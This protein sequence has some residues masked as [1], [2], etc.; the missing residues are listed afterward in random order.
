MTE[1]AWR[2][3]GVAVALAAALLGLRYGVRAADHQEA[4]PPAAV[5]LVQ[6]ERLQQALQAA[7]MSVPAQLDGLPAGPWPRVSLPQVHPADAA[8]PAPGV[9]SWY[10][11]T[12]PD[13]ALSAGSTAVLYVPR[14]HACLVLSVYVDG[15]LAT[16]TLGRSSHLH[17]NDPLWL[18]RLP[19][20]PGAS[21]HEL[22]LRLDAATRSGSALSTLWVGPGT[23]LYPGYELRRLLQRGVPAATSAAFLLLGLFSGVVWLRRRTESGYLLFFAMSLLYWLRC[24]H[25]YV[26]FGE[27]PP[28]LIVVTNWITVNALGWM[29]AVAYLFSLRLHGRRQ[30]RIEWPLFGLLLA[31]AVLTALGALGELGQGGLIPFA[32]NGVYPAFLTAAVGL[33]V[34]S[35]HAAWRA[36][37]ADAGWVAASLWLNIALGA[38]DLLLQRWLIDVEGVYLLP[39]GGVAMCSVFGAVIWRRYVEALRGVEQANEHLEQRLAQREQELQASFAQLREVQHRQVLDNERQRLMREMHDG[40]GATLM[41]SL[42]AVQGGQMGAA[43]VEA[44][45]RESVDELKIAIDSLDPAGNDVLVLLGTL[46][47]RLA[48]RLEAAGLTLHWQVNDLPALPWLTPADALHV[49]RIVQEVLTNIIKHAAATEVTVHTEAAATAAVLH[50]HDNGR[51]L[52]A[53]SAR[54]AGGRGLQNMRHRAAQ[55]G[56]TLHIESPAGAGTRVTLTLPLQ[57]AAAGD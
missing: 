28:G 39:L 53:G 40:L 35:S 22:V 20:S 37:S 26:D 52:A 6:A 36:R 46:R 13:Q 34:L 25:Y 15:T 32:R 55:L 16:T 8:A 5:H 33:T 48:P 51:G 30:P 43:A 31:A 17:F 3:C 12:V 27:M 18:N 21:S 19:A 44:M 41:S 2:R 56:A 4:A 47:Y 1:A 38:H 7:P 57:R 42:V 10:R 45:L 9:T 11:F 54:P 24:L 29:M 23:T 49:L 50:I 14:C